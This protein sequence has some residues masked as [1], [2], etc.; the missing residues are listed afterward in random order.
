MIGVVVDS[1]SN[2][3]GEPDRAGARAWRRVEQSQPPHTTND[4]E[5]PLGRARLQQRTAALEHKPC[6]APLIAHRAPQD[7]GTPRVFVEAGIDAATRYSIVTS[8]ACS[9]R[10]TIPAATD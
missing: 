7:R 8:D 10:V 3:P 4:R 9:L 1:L 2:G 5:S 6:P